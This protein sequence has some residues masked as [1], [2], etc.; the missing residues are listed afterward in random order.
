MMVLSEK[1]IH[2]F[3]TILRTKKQLELYPVIQKAMEIE[4]V[5]YDRCRYNAGLVERKKNFWEDSEALKEYQFTI[6]KIKRGMRDRDDDW[7]KLFRE[8]AKRIVHT[9]SQDG[10][11]KVI[12]RKEPQLRPVAASKQQKTTRESAPKGVPKARSDQKKKK[13]AIQPMMSIDKVMFESGKAKPMEPLRRTTVAPSAAQKEFTIQQQSAD[14]FAEA[15]IYLEDNIDDFMGLDV[16]VDAWRE[17]AH[18]DAID[19]SVCSSTGLDDNNWHLARQELGDQK[20]QNSK[21]HQ[22]AASQKDELRRIREERVQSAS[23][24]YEER[25]GRQLR[26]EEERRQRQEQIN[27]EREAQRRKREEEEQTINLDENKEAMDLFNDDDMF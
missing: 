6:D 14:Q 11:G 27:A 5:V 20:L 4:E 3:H 1:F 21:A 19:R 13:T 2:E 9:L 12:K 17:S 25:T 24:Q 7:V 26:E 16:D 15:D 23:T 10:G 18:A 22:I 8:D